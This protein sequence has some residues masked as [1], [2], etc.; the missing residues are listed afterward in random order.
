[1]ER[2]TKRLLSTLVMSPSRGTAKHVREALEQKTPVVP[3]VYD[4]WN[5][6]GCGGQSAGHARNRR[7]HDGAADKGQHFLK[8]ISPQ[9]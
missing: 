7:G 2:K 3:S 9:T 5:A 4:A 1:M 6:V 8:N